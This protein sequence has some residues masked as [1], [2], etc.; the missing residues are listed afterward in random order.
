MTRVETWRYV[1]HNGQV[2]CPRRLREVAVSECG[3]CPLLRGIDVEHG[4]TSVVCVPPP[5]DTV[6]RRVQALLR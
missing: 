1:V 3:G 2:L 5:G 6:R 4:S